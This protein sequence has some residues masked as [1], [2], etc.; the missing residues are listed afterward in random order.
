MNYKELSP[1]DIVEFRFPDLPTDAVKN[2]SWHKLY[3]GIFIVVAIRYIIND[4]NNEDVEVYLLDREATQLDCGVS[5]EEVY[6][7][8]LVRVG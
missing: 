4:E 2:K 8:N 6:V 1:G 7:N 5:A 3:E